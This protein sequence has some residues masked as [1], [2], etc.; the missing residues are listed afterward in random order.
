VELR[1]GS[2][3][4]WKQHSTLIQATMLYHSVLQ[5]RVSHLAKLEAELDLAISSCGAAQGAE[6]HLAVHKD[7]WDG[8]V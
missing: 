5:Q 1:E 7:P 6:A 3:P 4:R 8:F 2:D